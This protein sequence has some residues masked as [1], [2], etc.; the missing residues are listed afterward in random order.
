MKYNQTNEWK[1]AVKRFASERRK[2]NNNSSTNHQKNEQPI[3]I[4]VSFWYLL[5]MRFIRYYS[6]FVD[7]VEQCCMYIINYHPA[8]KEIQIGCGR[9]RKKKG[10]SKH[11]FLIQTLSLHLTIRLFFFCFLPL[12]HTSFIAS[13]LFLCAC[14][15]CIHHVHIDVSPNVEDHHF[16]Q[17]GAVP[18]WIGYPL[19][20]QILGD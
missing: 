17:C 7:F 14:V 8:L 15:L 19:E 18:T 3:R 20:F 5:S 16:M 11:L 6:S 13:L 12:P 2:A 1:N 10:P 9:E 4:F